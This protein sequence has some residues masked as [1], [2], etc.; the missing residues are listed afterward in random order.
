M[1]EGKP[2]GA[3]AATSLRSLLTINRTHETYYES[4]LKPVV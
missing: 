1:L 2:E 3:G 4:F